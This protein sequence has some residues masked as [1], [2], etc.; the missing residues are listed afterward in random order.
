MK[1]TITEN[2]LYS[3]RRND[4]SLE[5]KQKV[6]KLIQWKQSNAVP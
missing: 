2:V 1:I 3:C 6:L 4:A 5:L